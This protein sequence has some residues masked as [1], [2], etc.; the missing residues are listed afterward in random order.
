M[1]GNELKFPRI[2]KTST[3]EHK[4]WLKDKEKEYKTMNDHIAKG[5]LISESFFTL[6]QISQKRWQKIT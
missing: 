4:N 1:S 5:G 2:A 3:S 6:A